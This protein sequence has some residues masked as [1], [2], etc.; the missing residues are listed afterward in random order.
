[1]CVSVSVG[2]CVCGVEVWGCVWRAWVWGGVCE[3]GECVS[4]CVS[5]VVWGSAPA[6]RV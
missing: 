6:C 4:V 3:R 5:L 2:G 1:M